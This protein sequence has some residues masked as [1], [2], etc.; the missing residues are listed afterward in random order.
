MVDWHDQVFL[1]E[2]HAWIRSAVVV[3]GPIEQPHV[4]AWSTVLRAP[5][6][7]GWVWCKASAA[8]SSYEMRLTSLLAELRPHHVPEIIAVDDERAWML[9]RDAGVRLR[10]RGD[11][12]HAWPAVLPAYAEL[13]LATAPHVERLLGIGVPDERLERLP[14]RL[15]ALLD[16][17]HY[18]M[19]GEPDGLT[20]AE[21]DRLVAMLPEIGSLCQE[22]AQ[23]GL[24]ATIQHDDLHSGAVLVRDDRYRIADWGDA[25][26]SH[27]FHSLTVLLRATA[28]KLGLEP[29]G[30]ELLG[31]RDAY[32]EA[33]E[34]FG[35]RD[36]LVR[37][38]GIAYRTGTLVR[39]LAWQRY[40]SGLPPQERAEELDTIAY[41][42]QRF[43]E[44]GPL[45]AWRW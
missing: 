5:T 14:A 27:P 8:G 7:D 41:G 24:P 36:E 15:E 32:L 13:Q 38:A 22:L 9:M 29:G 45:G 4:E 10:E 12:L 40:L 35:S 44:N 34:G 20:P 2:I 23:A 33:F 11:E 26:V 21:R 16:D 25:C 3:T 6:A 39:A 18:L 30:P 28:W 19:L 31:M 42:L 43:L 1:Q 17:D 37:V